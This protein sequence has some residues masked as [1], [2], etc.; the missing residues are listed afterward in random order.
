ME[1]RQLGRSGLRV[2]VL[3]MGTMSFGGGGDFA[4]VG[5]TDVPG[6]RR[7]LDMCREHGVNIVDT[8][9]VYSAGRSEEIVGEALGSSRDDWLV[10]TKVRFP[11][12]PGPNDAGLSRHHILRAA[13]ASLRRLRTDY[14]D[15][16]QLHQWDGQTPIEETLGALQTLLDQGKVRYVGVSNYCGWQLLKALGTAD[17]LGLPR[18]ASEQIYYSLQARD[19]ESELLPAA[20][21]QGLGVLVWSPLAGGLLSGKYSRAKDGE[22]KGPKGARL[23]TEW[24]EPPIDFPDR[25]FATV[26][27]LKKIG[28]ARG[29]SA[30]QVALAWLLGRPAVTSLVIGARTEKQLADNLAAAELELTADE[31]ARLEKVSRPPLSYPHWH[32]RNTASERLSAADRVLLEPYL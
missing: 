23:L 10:A 30:A 15:L 12:G 24:N 21:D 25:L 8:A 17:R 16:Y 28:K 3:T 13:E 2:S 20:V 1:Y 29:V 19:A 6:A 32:T 26:D 14:I 9:D 27:V 22:L 5:D 7:Q 4:N 31:V 18:F 11:S